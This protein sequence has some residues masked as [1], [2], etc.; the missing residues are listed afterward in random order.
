MYLGSI[1]ILF[2][3][4]PCSTCIHGR[5]RISFRPNSREI[6]SL[7]HLSWPTNRSLY[8]LQL[9]KLKRCFSLSNRRWLVQIIPSSLILLPCWHVFF[10][11]GF[12]CGCSDFSGLLPRHV[13]RP[14]LSLYAIFSISSP[15]FCFTVFFKFPV[16]RLHT[17]GCSIL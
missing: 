2:V 8:K 3:P 11:V 4:V 17:P 13:A 10:L 1:W 12:V 15:Y 5:L 16:L 9:N 14:V 7:A 6:H